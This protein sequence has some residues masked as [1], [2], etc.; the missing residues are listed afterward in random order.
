MKSI[1]IEESSD[2]SLEHVEDSADSDSS[3]S[4]ADPF[5]SMT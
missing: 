1:C 2:T 5:M 3:E 4:E